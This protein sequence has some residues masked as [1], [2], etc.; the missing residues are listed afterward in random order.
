MSVPVLELL[1]H[2][3]N[4]VLRDVVGPFLF[5]EDALLRYLNEGYKLFARHTH[6]FVDDLET[7]TTVAGT[8]RYLLPADTIYVRQVSL[9]NTYLTPYTRRA[10]P[11][12]GLSGKPRAY[13]T[14]ARHKHIKLYATPDDVYEL[15]L[16]RAVSPEFVDQSDD[17][18]LDFEWAYMLPQWI[19]YRALSTNDPDGSNTV[20]AQGF[21][22]NWG[23]GLREAKMD[24]ARQ[25]MG[26]NPSAQPRKWT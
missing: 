16:E 8:A 3:R 24:F 12:L 25:A 9:G 6:C 22:Q 14:D 18:E 10:K 23:T 7:L 20:A 2:T 19:A 1:D 4:E 13:T 17:V 11:S 21:Y 26:D 5:S 15:E